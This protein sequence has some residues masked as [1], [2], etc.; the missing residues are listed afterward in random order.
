M[1]FKKPK[2]W[3]RSKPNLLSYILLP[4]TIP[5]LINNFYLKFK[6]IKKNKNIKSICIGNIYL[7]GTGKTPTTIRL[8]EILNELKSNVST[9]KKFYSSQSDENIILEK[10]TK[11]ISGKNRQNILKQ[12]IKNNQEIIIFDDGLQDRSISYDLSFVCFDNEKFIGNGCL[13][14]AGPLREKINSLTKY[15]GVFIKTETDIS[16]DILSSIKQQNPK[17]RIFQTYFEINNLKKFDINDKYLIF[18]GIGNPQSF[19]QILIKNNFNVL[20]EV[21][22][23]DHHNYKKKEI[24]NLKEKAK[25]I[26]AKLIT[27]EK[28]FVKVSKIDSENIDFLDVKLMIKNEES[29]KEFIKVKL[30][31]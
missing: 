31:E 15:D 28:D 19:K 10:R 12:C 6:S 23:P 30:H 29:L 2:F 9:A 24:K 20:E 1:R 5:V 8:Y 14:P 27:T 18:C 16:N 11:F 17:I 25:K 3:D 7:G 13:I 22:F 26:N 4:L 21:I